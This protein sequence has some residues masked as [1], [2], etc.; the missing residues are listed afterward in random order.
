[1]YARMY[2]SVSLMLPLYG[3]YKFSGEP[4]TVFIFDDN[5]QFHTKINLERN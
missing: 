2:D 1:M 3:R 5:F 4:K